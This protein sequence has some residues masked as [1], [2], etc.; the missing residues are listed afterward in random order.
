MAQ[1]LNGSKVMSVGVEVTVEVNEAM[2]NS[3][4]TRLSNAVILS[5]ESVLTIVT[6]QDLDAAFRYALHVVL[7]ADSGHRPIHELVPTFLA[8]I[9]IPLAA[10]Y[11]GVAIHVNVLEP[12]ARP[13]SYPAVLDVLR[14]MNIPL[15]NPLRIDPDGT[16]R[17]LLA[18]IMEMNGTDHLVSVEGDISLEELVVRSMLTLAHAEEERLR[19]VIGHMDNLYCSRDDLLR[20]W[21]CT[22]PVGKRG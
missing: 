13:N 18:G 17:V 19:R 5:N 2:I 4:A 21:A 3:I 14:S 16:S 10:K 22:L 1:T 15:G 9:T 6:A 20:E 8:D 12:G 7:A 11:R